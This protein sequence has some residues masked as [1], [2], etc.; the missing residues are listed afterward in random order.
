MLQLVWFSECIEH[1]LLLRILRTPLFPRLRQLRWHVAPDMQ[2]MTSLLCPSLEVLSILPENNFQPKDWEPETENARMAVIRLLPSLAPNLNVLI[3]STPDSR[4]DPDLYN[5]VFLAT[6]PLLSRL[7]VFRC[8][9]SLDSS[10]LL[11]LSTSPNLRWLEFK[12][13]PLL[14]PSLSPASFPSLRGLAMRDSSVNFLY[15]LSRVTSTSL[16][17]I[18]LEFLDARPILS[19][20]MNSISSQH[21]QTLKEIW[22][23]W[24]QSTGPTPLEISILTP[25]YACH[26]ITVAHIEAKGCI[27]EIYDADLKDIAN[28][29][30]KLRSLVVHQGCHP[31]PRPRVSLRGLHDLVTS[32]KFLTSLT[33]AIDASIATPS[34]PDPFGCQGSSLRALHLQRSRCGDVVSVSECFEHMFP[35]LV[36]FTGKRWNGPVGAGDPAGRW[37]W[38][39]VINRLSGFSLWFDGWTRDE[40]F[41]FSPDAS[42]APFRHIMEES[43][44]SED[45]DYVA[46]TDEGDGSSEGTQWGDEEWINDSDSNF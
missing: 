23:T 10:S 39:D 7:E 20:I 28:A 43:D 22:L 31:T 36:L 3:S 26:R 24:P 12:S 17:T 29:W 35:K 13:L 44:D 6:V 40:A 45:E 46:D 21:S 14:P 16:S 38:D 30:P 18:R 2:G 25:L 33:L 11:F 41:A 32:C 5:S 37:K 34:C 15:I 19:K 42:T 9:I 1:L 8:D 4:P 27:V